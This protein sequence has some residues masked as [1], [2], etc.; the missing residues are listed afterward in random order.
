MRALVVFA[1]VLG[2]AL[3]AAVAVRLL[4]VVL[5]SVTKLGELVQTVAASDSPDKPLRPFF[6]GG[7]LVLTA[8]GV[9][10]GL[11]VTNPFWQKGLLHDQVTVSV[12]RPDWPVRS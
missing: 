1:F 10:G 3:I 6:V 8:V 2:L 11:L 5:R 9:A 12:T 4:E 7:G